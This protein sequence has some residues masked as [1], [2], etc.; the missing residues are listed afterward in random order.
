ML[1]ATVE[2]VLLAWEKDSDFSKLARRFECTW[3]QARD[4]VNILWRAGF[5]GDEITTITP[6]GHDYIRRAQLGW[7]A[8]G[9][10]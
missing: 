9:E 1:I 7:P 5:V 8:Q 3:T 2:D 6:R 10:V 4:V